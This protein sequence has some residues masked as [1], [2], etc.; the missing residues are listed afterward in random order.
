MTVFASA[1]IT[2]FKSVRRARDWRVRLSRDAADVPGLRWLKAMATLGDARTG[3]FAAGLPRLRR[4]LTIAAW[5]SPDDFEA[6]YARSPL[7]SAWHDD[8]DHAWH[9]LLQPWRTTGSFRGARPFV[10]L[11]S[12]EPDSGPLAVLTLGRCSWRRLGAFTREGTALASNILRSPGLITALTAG[13]PVTG[14]ATFSLWERAEDMHAF[15]YLGEGGNGHRATIESDRRRPIL[16]EQITARLA[17]VGIRGR[18]DGPT[19]PNAN[20]LGWLA[21]RLPHL[22][23]D[24]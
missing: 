1:H 3:G 2:D 19:T 5:D 16:E 11:Q 14:N 18:W 21:Q 20:A 4:Q 15:A 12:A 23:Q 13:F 17:P 9:V 6:F 10:D 24:N 22:R 8:C 7:A